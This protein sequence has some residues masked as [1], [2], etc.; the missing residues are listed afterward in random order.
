[1]IIVNGFEVENPKESPELVV[2]NPDTGDT[3]R[4]YPED[5]Y[6]LLEIATEQED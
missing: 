1:M 4:I 3:L 2:T 6:D 5:L